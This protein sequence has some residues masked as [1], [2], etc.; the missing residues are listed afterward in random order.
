MGGAI[1]TG[2]TPVTQEDLT[3]QVEPCVP[4]PVTP[5]SPVPPSSD[6][7]PFAV[8]TNAFR[9][10]PVPN[11]DLHRHAPRR[12]REIR[13]ITA[14]AR[15]SIVDFLSIVSEGRQHGVGIDEY[16]QL[17]E[18]LYGQF[19]VSLEVYCE[20]G[21]MFL[22]S[23]EGADARAVVRIGDDD[24]TD[25]IPPSYFSWERTSNSPELDRLWNLRHDGVGPVIHIERE[26]VNRSC[27]FNCLV[28]IESLRL[29]NL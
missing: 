13:D 7:D 17:A 4:E 10:G 5:Q 20:N 11:C 18:Y 19:Y 14:H 12:N 15:M 26:D 28:P 8:L 2:V 3:I 6:E 16:V 29:L 23:G 1:Q 22:R 27:T 9:T 24:V 21:A 25:S